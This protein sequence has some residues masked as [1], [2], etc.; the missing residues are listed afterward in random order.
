MNR[1]VSSLNWGGGVFTP[2][3][4]KCKNI[5]GPWDWSNLVSHS[6][7]FWKEPFENLDK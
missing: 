6:D 1:G 2:I 7:I 3:G 5:T 4:G